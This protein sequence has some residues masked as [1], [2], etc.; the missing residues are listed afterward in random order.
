MALPDRTPRWELVCSMLASALKKPES[1]ILIPAAFVIAVL[2]SLLA[3]LPIGTMALSLVNQGLKLL[4]MALMGWGAVRS[5]SP[6]GRQA[7]GR[8]KYYS[9]WTVVLLVGTTC[10]MIVSFLLD[11]HDQRRATQ[12]AIDRQS[13]VIKDLRRVVLPLNDAITAHF[14]FRMDANQHLLEPLTRSLLPLGFRNGKLEYGV[15]SIAEID[16]R[17]PLHAPLADFLRQLPRSLM[18]CSTEGCFSCD[19]AIDLKNPRG[20]E[21]LAD[22]PLGFNVADQVIAAKSVRTILRINPP[23]YEIG[24]N[25]EKLRFR[26]V[27]DRWTNSEDLAKAVTYFQA[28]WGEFK[29]ELLNGALMRADGKVLQMKNLT[30]IDRC[31][32]RHYSGRLA[33]KWL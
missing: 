9:E 2:S 33:E 19:L 3:M 27:T 20:V 1:E 29:Y 6:S 15:L 11:F 12:E 13:Q 5:I 7:K 26:A 16:S 22:M 18:M 17:H 8:S 14:S 23:Q 21:L 4:V 31:G 25:S 30:M 28:P 10:I 32:T 24:L